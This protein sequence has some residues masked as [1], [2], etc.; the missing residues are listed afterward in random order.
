MN[1]IKIIRTIITTMFLTTK[2]NQQKPIRLDKPTPN[3]KKLKSIKTK[4][5]AIL[6]SIKTKLQAIL[7]YLLISLILGLILLIICLLIFQTGS[8]EST[9]IYNNRLI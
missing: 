7:P 2:P 8:M 5:R 3:Q 9:G 6:K 1:I 4:F